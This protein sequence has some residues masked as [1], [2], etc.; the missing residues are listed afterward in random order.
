MKHFVAMVLVIGALCIPVRAEFLM[1]TCAVADL[2]NAYNRARAVFL[3]EV[4]DIVETVYPN[5][6]ARGQERAFSIRFKVEKAWKGVFTSTFEVLSSYGED[7]GPLGFPL[8]RKGQRYV[9]YADPIFV[10]YGK[11]DP[12]HTAIS[13]CSRTASVSNTSKRFV[14]R[15]DSF[16]RTNG[17]ADV[18]ILDWRYPPLTFSTSSVQ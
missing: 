9:V 15:L 14:V 3:G 1:S 18:R 13:G 10:G 11:Y 6:T 7:A 5:Q 12:H 8:M 17:A 16:D 2:D 4:T